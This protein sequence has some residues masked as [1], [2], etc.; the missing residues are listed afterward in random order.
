MAHSKSTFRLGILLYISEGASIERFGPMPSQEKLRLV[1]LGSGF[2]GFSLLKQID[3][4]I[5]DVTAVSPRNYFLFTP[6]LPSTTV[7]TIGF[8]S[9]IEP[10]RHV[11]PDVRY[12]HARCTYIDVKGKNIA[13]EGEGD[14]GQFTLPYDIL[15]IAI[16][17]VSNTYGIPGVI[18]HA[19]FL[20]DIRDAQLIRRRLIECFEQAARPGV[21][22]DDRRRLLHFVV[23][24]GG[25]T[26]VEVTAEMHDFLRQDLEEVFPDL[27]PH[28]TITLLEA[29]DQILNAF[30]EEL[31][32]YTTRLFQ[33]R[34][35]Q[36]CTG[37]LVVRVD[38]HTIFLGNGTEIPY[39]LAVWS[40]G[41]GPTELART[42]PFPKDRDFCILTDEYFRVHGTESIYAI[43]DC[44][45]VGGKNLPA[46]AQ[47]A[48][49]QG[50]FLARHLKGVKRGKPLQAFRY[51]HYGMLAYVGGRKA[52]ADLES[53]KGRGFSTWLFWRSA[54][55][56]R[57][58]SLK[59][60]LLVLFDWFITFIFGRDISRL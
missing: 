22:P 28:V 59:N 58:V 6:L 45:L 31:R 43:G 3:T 51:R 20:K 4:N 47:V 5:F 50:R 38:K 30:D 23:V 10:I 1:V 13:C 41:I 48:Q 2:A 33:R 29:A 7:G 55:L 9:I 37:S 19:L 26:G 14:R 60:K 56:T 35:I 53:F 46:T 32:A 27:A 42:L 36:V 25:P 16:G 57:L 34:R 40:T 15:V 54:Y 24:G 11:S 49:Q 39:G 18:E 21:T 17:A 12:Y 8:R 52:L 44:A